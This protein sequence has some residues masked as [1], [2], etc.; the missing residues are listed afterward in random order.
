MEDQGYCTASPQYEEATIGFNLVMVRANE[1]T[2]L[3]IEDLVVHELVHCMVWKNSERAVT[4]VT[5]AL[6]RASR[7]AF[8]AQDLG[9]KA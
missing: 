7:G 4:Q 2:P 3:E 6:L 9:H 1:L 8:V 5:R